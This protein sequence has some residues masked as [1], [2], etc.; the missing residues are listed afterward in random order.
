VEPE[1]VLR[2][3]LKR[4]LLGARDAGE[5]RQ[6]GVGLGVL[7]DCDAL[8]TGEGADDDIGALLLD[9]LADLVGDG[10][11]GVIATPDADELYRGAVDLGALPALEGGRLGV[12]GGAGVLLQREGD[13]GDGVLVEAAEGAF[14]LAEDAQLDAFLLACAG[15]A[16][17]AAL[18][19]RACLVG[20]VPAAAAGQQG[21]CRQEGSRDQPPWVA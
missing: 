8:V 2:L 5:H 4:R 10:V 19:R 11:G 1:E 15:C 12:D 20:G 6:V 9:E 21:G 18:G 14:A 17:A 13:T 16:F 3:H 7:R